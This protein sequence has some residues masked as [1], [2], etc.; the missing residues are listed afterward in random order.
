MRAL[1]TIPLERRDPAL[2]RQQL[3]ELARSG[4][5]QTWRIVIFPEGGIAPAGERLPF[6]SGAF[7]LAI[8]TANPILPVAIRGTD[9]ALPPR[10][11]LAVRPG[12]VT[13][14][15]L[16]PISTQGLG[17]ADRGELRDSVRDIVVSA[18]QC[19]V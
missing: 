7:S 17:I 13:V 16:A 6:K 14:Q 8:Q 4:S 11:F 12:L 10:S 9:S 3:V 15:I 5:S 18:L 1:H 2:A 19:D